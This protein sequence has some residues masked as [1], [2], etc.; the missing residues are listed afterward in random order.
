MSLTLHQSH[1]Y[2]KKSL[3]HPPHLFLYA[4]LCCCK[5]E[6][7]A[8]V[9]HIFN[10]MYNFGTTDA[11]FTRMLATNVVRGAEINQFNVKGHIG[12]CNQMT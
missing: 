2:K 8:S 7:D 3:P 12:T 1:L 10:D 11:E 4:S 5:H 6:Y 9:L